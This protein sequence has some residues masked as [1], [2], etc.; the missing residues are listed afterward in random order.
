MEKSYLDR[1][2]RGSTPSSARP[3]LGPWC[4]RVGG[5]GTIHVFDTRTGVDLP[6]VSGG[7]RH[8]RSIGILARRRRRL[9]TSDF[10]VALLWHLAYHDAPQ[11]FVGHNGAVEAARFSP[12]GT[13]WSPSGSDKTLI[14]WDLSGAGS[15][16]DAVV[17]RELGLTRH[18]RCGRS[19]RR[20]RSASS[21]WVPCSFVDLESGALTGPAA[22]IRSPA[23]T[24]FPR[25]ARAAAWDPDG[26][27]E[28]TWP[29]GSRDTVARRWTGTVD[30]ATE[31]H[32]LPRVRLGLAG[33][34]ARGVDPQRRRA[35]GLRPRHPCSS[36]V[37]CDRSRRPRRGD[38]RSWSR[39]GRRTGAPCW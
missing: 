29:N 26:R 10:D 11:R 19:G 16:W 20:S 21:G 18:R 30:L 38:A 1:R 7:T 6:V 28:T 33:R 34:S 22:R 14:T 9:V 12:T 13:R 8:A 15:V 37:S 5:D 2:R 39:A 35:G 32:R 25:H 3:S 31:D 17:T 4:H 27:H 23:P 36:C 24:T